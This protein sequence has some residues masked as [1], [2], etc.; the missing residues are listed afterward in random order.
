MDYSVKYEIQTL[1]KHKG[2]A[3]VFVLRMTSIAFAIAAVVGMWQ[4]ITITL[5]RLEIKSCLSHMRISEQRFFDSTLNSTA[6]QKRPEPT[7]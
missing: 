5:F 4:S 3:W 1:T 6:D 7:L 2:K